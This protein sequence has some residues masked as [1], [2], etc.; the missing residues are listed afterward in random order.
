MESRCLGV[1]TLELQATCTHHA[2]VPAEIDAAH[3]RLGAPEPFQT[4]APEVLS[5]VA[6]RVLDETPDGPVQ[7]AHR[8]VEVQPRA[9]R[10]RKSAPVVCLHHGAVLLGPEPGLDREVGEVP[11]RIVHTRVL[12][13]DQVDAP[14]C[15]KEISR[16]RV[17]VAGYEGSWR[18][19]QRQAHR[20]RPLPHLVVILG[21]R[22]PPT[23]QEVKVTVDR[24][25][26]VEARFEN[27][28]ETVDALERP[29]G[30]YRRPRVPAKLVPGVHGDPFDEPG[31]HRAVC[32]V[33]EDHLRAYP[34]LGRDPRVVL[35]GATVYILRSAFP[36]QPQRVSRPAYCDL[37]SDVGEPAA[38]TF[39]LETS[40]WDVPEK[41]HACQRGIYSTQSYSSPY[42]LW[43]G[44]HQRPRCSRAIVNSTLS[45]RNLTRVRS[46][47][48]CGMRKRRLPG[49]C[50]LAGRRCAPRRS[51]ALPSRPASGCERG[52]GSADLRRPA[53]RSSPRRATPC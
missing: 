12:P 41:G 7:V 33:E 30:P 16:P 11:H 17:V 6:F 5:G 46:W 29:R 50:G 32:R 23:T 4:V 27:P 44:A 13:V 40:L 2:Q 34:G 37:V 42:L 47:F 39:D 9:E 3:P 8:F 20:P 15:V 28:P 45:V 18:G 51:P 43:A 25:E 14:V 24:G 36:G 53:T 22:R 52:S 10:R 31:H 1:R 48:I 38:E 21:Q 26:N 35:L 19:L 49:R